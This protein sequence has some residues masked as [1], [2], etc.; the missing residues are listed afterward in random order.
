MLPLFAITSV[1]LSGC[2]NNCG[3]KAE[4]PAAE[5]SPAAAP[6]AADA[7][8]PAPAPAAADANQ[9]APAPADPAH[10]PADAHTTTPEQKK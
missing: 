6:V 8:Q 5:Q 9:P 1:L 3:G 7:N 2:T 4:T 10:A